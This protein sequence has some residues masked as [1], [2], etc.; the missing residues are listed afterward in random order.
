MEICRDC[1]LIQTSILNS[2]IK[3]DIQQNDHANTEIKD[4]T[5]IDSMYSVNPHDKEDCLKINP[6]SDK[7]NLSNN[8]Y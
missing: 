8:N 6:L 5:S 7:L 3:S 4:N 1:Y 2:K